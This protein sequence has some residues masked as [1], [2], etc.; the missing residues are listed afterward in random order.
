VLDRILRGTGWK[1]LGAI[2]P[3]STLPTP[4][5]RLR[6]W[7]PLL[8]IRRRDLRAFLRSRGIPWREDASNRTGGYRR[9][10]LRAR[11]LPLL[12]RL[13]PEVDQVLGRLAETAAEEEAW[14][15]GSARAWAARLTARRG[16]RRLEVRLAAFGRAPVAAQRRMVR[17][18][19]M[20][21]NPGARGFRFDRVEDVR[22][23]WSG[24]KKGP[25]D[26]GFGLQAS[27]R[28]GRGVLASAAP[29]K[30]Q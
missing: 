9:N 4:E 7:R 18:W 8:G 12:R 19:V 16:R 15:D 2:R 27:R 25:W 17:L 24:L 3:T 1:G 30:V 20:G 6:L 22:M 10:L 13:Q 23:V 28:G 26:L 5:G 11:V 14:L 29:K 21:L